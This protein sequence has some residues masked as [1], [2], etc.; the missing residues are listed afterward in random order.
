MF[1]NGAADSGRIGGSNRLR[2][3]RRTDD[4]SSQEVVKTGLVARVKQLWMV[5]KFSHSIVVR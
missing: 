1:N 5:N 3:N 4:Q 2:H